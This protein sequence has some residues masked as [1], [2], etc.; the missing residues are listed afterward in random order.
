MINCNTQFGKLKTV[1]VGKE[2]EIPTRILDITLKNFYKESLGS[3]L[4]NSQK[5]GYTINADILNKRIQQLDDLAKTLSD[6][7]VNVYR[8]NK[9][10]HVKK[11]QTPYYSTEHSSPNNV[12]DITLVYHD[13]IIETPVCIRN[14]VFENI[15]LYSIFKQMFNNGKGGKWIKA[16]NTHL[17]ENT[18]DFADWKTQRDFT[19]IPDN[20]EMAIDAPNFLTIGKDVIV[21]V[22][23]YSQYLGY[24]WV[25]SFF[26]DSS[27]HVIHCADNHID[28]IIR[29]VRPGVF[30]LNPKFKHVIQQ[31]PDKFKKWKFII[32]D[33]TSDNLD[34]TGM[35]DIDIQ[36]A[37]SRG[38]DI[39]V[40]CIDSNT[41]LVNKLATS[42]IKALA[43]NNFNVIA[44][45]L[46][47]GEIFGGGINCSTLDLERDDNYIYY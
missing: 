35:T 41:V 28:G 1:V 34:V 32:P 45:Q 10:T 9:V 18:Y 5:V 22:T 21:N 44:V 19:R 38:M 39:N 36:L 4:Y 13:T 20:I 8:P 6:F 15:E 47:N 17:L 43:K 14:R 23:T 40:L 27:F 26:P 24:L 25:K 46:D 37:S 29:N 7:G 42:T 11:I 33:D 16:P 3:G 2:L 30:L 12:R 31:L